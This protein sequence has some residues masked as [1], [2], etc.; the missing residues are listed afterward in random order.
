VIRS[1]LTLAVVLPG[2]LLA[3]IP[4]VLPYLGQIAG[5]LIVLLFGAVA[6]LVLRARASKA[7]HIALALAS[8]ARTGFLFVEAKVAPQLRGPD[9]KLPTDAQA[10]AKA[11]AVA[12][13]LDYLRTQALGDL[14][15]AYG[16]TDDE[17]ATEL[18]VQIDQL[19]QQ[20]PTGPVTAEKVIVTLP[21]GVRLVK[22]AGS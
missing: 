4:Y 13:A 9:G 7:R 2:F 12:A 19:A 20:M 14:K 18:G 1:L 22:P 8:A 17:L 5:T 10:L 15:K 6:H 11:A 16:K 21:S 3:L